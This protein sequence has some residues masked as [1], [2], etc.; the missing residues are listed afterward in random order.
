MQIQFQVEIIYH[1]IET[2]K[3]GVVQKQS[4]YLDNP[5]IQRFPGTIYKGLRHACLPG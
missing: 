4:K 3:A 1:T 5:W 2:A